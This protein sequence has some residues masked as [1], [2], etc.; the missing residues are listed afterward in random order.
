[1]TA[2]EVPASPARAMRVRKRVDA[3]PVATIAA[4]GLGSGPASFRVQG[5]GDPTRGQGRVVHPL[6]RETMAAGVPRDRLPHLGFGI[7]RWAGSTAE[8]PHMLVEAYHGAYR[9]PAGAAPSSGASTRSRTCPSGIGSCAGRWERSRLSRAQAD[10]LQRRARVGSRRRCATG[11]GPGCCLPCPSPTRPATPDGRFRSDRDA[12]RNG[13]GLRRP[14]RHLLGNAASPFSAE[15]LQER[16]RSPGCAIAKDTVHRLPVRLRGCFPVRTVWVEADSGRRRSVRA[17]KAHPV[18]PAPIRAFAPTSAT[19]S[20]RPCWWRCHDGGPTS[21]TAPRRRATRWTSCN[22]PPAWRGRPLSPAAP[23]VCARR[24]DPESM[25]SRPRRT[26]GATRIQ[27]R[28]TGTDLPGAV[29]WYHGYV[30]TLS[31]E[32]ATPA[33]RTGLAL[34][35]IIIGV[36]L[37]VAGAVGVVE[38]RQDARLAGRYPT[39]RYLLMGARRPMPVRLQL[40]LLIAICTAI[41]VLLLARS[42]LAAG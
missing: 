10:L 39:V 6:R 18:A 35:A 20:R 42:W 2:A 27:P 19:P 23:T 41:L 28:P 21:G 9:P 33:L 24:C 29:T 3:L 25:P 16:L 7:E 32:P 11:W 4:P 12:V 17:R 22:G 30:D 40:Q 38:R 37:A 5:G 1:M 36:L 34:A 31:G 26:A 14:A 15:R 8:G 13:A